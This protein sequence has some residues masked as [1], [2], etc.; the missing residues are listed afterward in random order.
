VT[1]ASSYRSSKKQPLYPRARALRKHET[2]VLRLRRGLPHRRAQFMML[3]AGRCRPSLWWCGAWTRWPALRRAPVP[4]FPWGGSRPASISAADHGPRRIP[5]DDFDAPTP[6]VFGEKERQ[7]GLVP[8]CDLCGAVLPVQVRGRPRKRCDGCSKAT[9]NAGRRVAPAAV[10][11][12]GVR[13]VVP[14]AQREP[15]L[16]PPMQRRGVPREPSCQVRCE[17]GTQG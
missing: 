7:S 6:M 13:R 3:G 2:G 11:C 5:G 15:L 8:S 12:V 14:G 1:G 9:Y 16:R 10:V 4:C 17:A